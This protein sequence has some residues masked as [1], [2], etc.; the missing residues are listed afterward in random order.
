MDPLVSIKDWLI[1]YANSLISNEGTQYDNRFWENVNG[2]R[3]RNSSD[4]NYTIRA[5]PTLKSMP[6]LVTPE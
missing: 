2:I 1:V 3:E 6:V 5:I 4:G